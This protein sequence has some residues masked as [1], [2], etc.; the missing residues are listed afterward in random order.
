MTRIQSVSSAQVHELQYKPLS[1]AQLQA[2]I[3]LFSGDQMER[4][5]ALNVG[6]LTIALP[7]MDPQQQ[8]SIANLFKNAPAAQQEKMAEAGHQLFEGL[9]A[10][11]GKLTAGQTAPPELKALVTATIQSY[12]QTTGEQNADAAVQ[13]SMYMA[14]ASADADVYDFAAQL[15]A[16]L[17]EKKSIREEIAD[18]RDQMGDAKYDGPGGTST[19]TI[20]DE[21]GNEKQVTMTK[22]QAEAHMGNLESKLQTA[23]DMTQEMQMQL[24][25]AM[26]KQAQA[27]QLL[28]NIMK[29]FHD[30]AK[31][32]IGNM[33][34]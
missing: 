25:D 18:F 8:T 19:F 15:K 33:R 23:S 5:K 28:S 7:V 31:A 24:Q 16:N 10:S 14:V 6:K 27:I 12:Q 34:G 11:S 1:S 21:N 20:K 3:R 26:N 4:P 2:R 17:D 30:T 22:E 9:A 13:G 32:I 29:M